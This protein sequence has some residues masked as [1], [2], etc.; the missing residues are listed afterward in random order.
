VAEEVDRA[1]ALFAATT[2]TPE[3]CAASVRPGM[4]LARAVYERV[5]D[6]VERL[7]FDVLGRRAALAPWELARAVGAGWR[8]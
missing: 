3:L 7:G 8:P 1:L 4:R 5:L 2:T 6:R